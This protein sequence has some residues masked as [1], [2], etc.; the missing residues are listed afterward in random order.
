MRKGLFP[1]SVSVSVFGLGYVGCVSAAC[2]AGEGRRVIGVDVAQA[3]VDQIN[4]GRSTIVEDGIAEMVATVVGDGRLT[5]TTDVHAA[6]IA[7]DISLV[8]VGTPSR[9][10]RPDLHPS[11][12]SANRCGIARKA[13]MAHRGYPQYRY[14]GHD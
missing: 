10:H 13:Q 3:K 4:A 8:C 2:F 9:Q 5:A 11:G 14:A 1:M 7:S 12:L 6:V